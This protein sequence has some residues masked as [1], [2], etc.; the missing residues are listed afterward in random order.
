MDLPGVHI[1]IQDGLK[2]LREGKATCHDDIACLAACT[3]LQQP[4]G[5]W[6]GVFHLSLRQLGKDHVF[7][8]QW[9]RRVTHQRP[10]VVICSGGK[11]ALKSGSPPG[12]IGTRQ[13][14]GRSLLG[15]YKA[16]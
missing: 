6:D 8:Q 1:A 4:F 9:V 2:I 15:G 12:Q 5:H 3:A 11:I 14:L 16:S 13:T 7:H 10:G